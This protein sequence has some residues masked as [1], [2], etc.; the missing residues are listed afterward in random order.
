[1]I[2]FG[3]FSSPLPRLVRRLKEG[4]FSLLMECFTLNTWLA[5]FLA[6]FPNN[7]YRSNP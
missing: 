3:G 7:C 4:A 2:T 6:S 5:C 1:M